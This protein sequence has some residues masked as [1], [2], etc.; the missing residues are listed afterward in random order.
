MARFEQIEDRAN[1]PEGAH[2]AGLAASLQRGAQ[3]AQAGL[4][5]NDT[6]NQY[7]PGTL[8]NG[9]DKSVIPAAPQAGE[10]KPAPSP[11]QSPL[12]DLPQKS[13]GNTH[14]HLTPK[15]EKPRFHR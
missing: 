6:A 9:T 4:K 15:A 12:A 8:I 7:L 1:S 11:P 14:E 2:L 13:V 3:F 5:M 10:Q